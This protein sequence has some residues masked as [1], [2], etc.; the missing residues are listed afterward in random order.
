MRNSRYAQVFTLLV[1]TALQ[2][3]VVWQ[4]HATPLA[5]KLAST[6]ATPQPGDAFTGS[7]QQPREFGQLR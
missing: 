6:I 2:V 4:D 1:A 5:G 7:R 3:S